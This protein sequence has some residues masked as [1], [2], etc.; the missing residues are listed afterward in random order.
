MTDEVERLRE[1]AADI[2]ASIIGPDESLPEFCTRGGFYDTTIR[3]CIYGSRNTKISTLAKIAA[4][5]GLRIR[6]RLERI[7]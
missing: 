2:V 7:E 1:H 5:N 6:M 4:A 3:A